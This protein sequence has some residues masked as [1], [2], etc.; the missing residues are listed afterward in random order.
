MGFFADSAELKSIIER[1]GWTAY[2]L[3]NLKGNGSESL[4]EE[5]EQTEPAEKFYVDRRFF[6]N[7][8]K[9]DK[10]RYDYDKHNNNEYLLVKI[11]E[12]GQTIR[13]A[14]ASTK[15]L[16]PALTL[17]NV[18]DHRNIRGGGR[19][20]IS[21][22]CTYLFTRLF[23]KPRGLVATSPSGLY[24]PRSPS[25]VVPY[26]HVVKVFERYF[27]IVTSEEIESSVFSSSLQENYVRNFFQRSDEVN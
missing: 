14:C 11:P 20:I 8:E 21:G 5:L 12:E 4:W 17:P 19:L 22:L 9:S 15:F 24:F 23:F 26:Q 25:I 18:E 10:D 1:Q 3:N 13:E 7:K 16:G 2:H 27:N 6:Y